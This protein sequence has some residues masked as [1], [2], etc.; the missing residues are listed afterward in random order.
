MKN[1]QIYSIHIILFVVTFL[2]MTYRETSFVMIANWDFTFA[3]EILLQEIWY[4]F[5]LIFI[6]FSHEMGHFIPA[7]LFGIR[8]TL[9]YFIPFPFGPIGTMG[10]VIR[11]FD[12]ITDKIKLFDI[13]VG[14]PLMSLVLS[15]PCWIIG[16]FLS[17]LVPIDISVDTSQMVFF[18]DSLFTYWTGQWILGPYET[19]HFDVAIHP[20][21]KAGWVGLLVT[22]INLLPFGQLDGGHII[23]SIFGE[24]YRKWIYWIFI[25]FLILALYNFTW[26]IWGFL[27]FYAIRIEHPFV[28]DPIDKKMGLGRILLGIIM[29]LSLILIFVPN[30]ISIGL[31]YKNN[32]LIQDIWSFFS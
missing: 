18:G 6:L 16:L 25:L 28:P 1:F 32:S 2:S 8:S 14:G 26:L 30:P 4:S 23:Y 21:A 29:L 13:G 3:Y 17:N 27:I 24:S 11:I 19:S 22:A 5:P 7:R 15:V 9:P 20:L 31:D 10:A 12:R